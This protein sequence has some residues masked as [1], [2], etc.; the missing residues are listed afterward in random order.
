MPFSKESSQPW[1]GIQ[2]SHIVGRFF[3][4]WVT[5]EAHLF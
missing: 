4:I 1:D 5:G 3:T 2:V